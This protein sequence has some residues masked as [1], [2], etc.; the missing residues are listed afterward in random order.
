MWIFKTHEDLRQEQFATQLINEEITTY[1][2]D[3]KET[4]ITT[5][6]KL[7]E[8]KETSVTESQEIK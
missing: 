6:E 3:M 4:F 2:F 1:N 5:T 8:K 7:T